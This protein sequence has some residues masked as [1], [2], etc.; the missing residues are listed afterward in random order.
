MNNIDHARPLLEDWAS[1]F[2]VKIAFFHDWTDSS[3][4]RV[5]AFGY[6]KGGKAKHMTVKAAQYLVNG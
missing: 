6:D 4:F 1:E 5:T 3:E 2:G